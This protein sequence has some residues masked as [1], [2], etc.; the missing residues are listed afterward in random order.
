MLQIGTQLFL[1]DLLFHIFGLGIVFMRKKIPVLLFLL[2]AVS[3][4][5]NARGF[6]I[7]HITNLQGLSNSSVNIVY[8]DSDNLMWFGT[9]DGLNRYNGREIRSWH[10]IPGDA[11]SISSNII[12]DITETEDGNLWIATDRGIDRFDREKE[13][14]VRYFSEAQGSITTEHLFDIFKDR[15]GQLFAFVDGKGIYRYDKGKDDFYLILELKDTHCQNIQT[16]IFDRV[17]ILTKKESLFLAER[18]TSGNGLA[19]KP[20]PL[21]LGQTHIQS[22]FVSQSGTLMWV[23]T[24]DGRYIKYD[25][26]NFSPL[27]IYRNSGKPGKI[28]SAHISESENIV[29]TAK[30]LYRFDISDGNFSLITGEAPVFS[31]LE[32]SQQI[33]WAGTDMHGVLAISN[34]EG[35]FN[36]YPKNSSG[37]IFG[38]SAVRCFTDDERGRLWVGT[39]GSGVF[40]FSGRGDNQR[41]VS[42]YTD[43][44]GLLNNSIYSLVTD[45]DLIWIGSDGLGLNYFD[46]S[47]SR[48]SALKIP[49]ELELGSIYCILPCGKDTLWIG[50]SGKGVFKLTLDKR[51]TP[52]SVKSYVQ[53]RHSSSPSSLSNDVVYSIIKDEYGKIWMATRGGGLCRF[54]ESKNEFT[55]IR[56]SNSA[57]GTDGAED[58]ICLCKD[59]AGGIWAGTNM[60]VFRIDNAN[61]D[62][63]EWFSTING[64][65]GNTIRGILEDSNGDIWCSTNLGLARI[66]RKD[67][68]H[69]ISYNTEDGLHN[70]EFSDLAAFS[71]PH[72]GT[73]F[74]GGINGYTWFDPTSVG[75]TTSFPNLVLDEFFVDNQKT[76][77][78]SLIKER[79]G[80][81]ELVIGNNIKSVALHFCPVD[82]ISSDKCEIAYLLEGFNKDWIELGTSGTIVLSKLK[83]GRYTLMVKCSNSDR[84]WSN[85][86]L[87]MPVRVKP[88]WYAS[89][90]ALF[91]Y[92]IL[93]SLIILFLVQVRNL[94]RKALEK[95][96]EKEKMKDIHEAKLQFF[97]NIAHEFSNSLTLIYGPCEDLLEDRKIPSDERASLKII[98]SN[99]DRMQQLIKQ[100]ISF[101]KA[102]TGHLN[103]KI[104][105]VDIDKLVNKVTEYYCDAFLK[106]KIKFNSSLPSHGFMWPTDRD[107]VEKIIFNFLS[108]AM[109]YTPEG[110]KIN[111]S[112][113]VKDERMRIAVTNTGVGIKKEEQGAVFDRYKVLNKFEKDIIKGKV[114]NGIGLAMC[115]NLAEL[116]KGEIGI[117][118][119]ENSFTTF[120]VILPRLELDK[121]SP[122]DTS[123]ELS[124]SVRG[125]DVREEDVRAERVFKSAVNGP[126]G[127]RKRVLVVDDDNE[128]RLFIMNLIKEQYAVDEASDGLEALEKIRKNQADLIISDLMM[129]RMDGVG[130]LKEIRETPNT[131]HIPVILLSASTTTENRLSG[132]ERGADAYLGK[133]F[134][135]RMLMATVK[136]LIERQ[137]EIRSYSDSAQAA[138]EQYNDRIVKKED[139][140]L[141]FKITDIIVSNKANEDLS[142]DMIANYMCM[143][144]IQLYRKCKELTGL[145]PVEYIRKI[146]LDYA[147]KLLKTT[148]SNIQEVMFACGFG[149]KTYF[150]RE[151]RKFYNCTPKQYR[152]QEA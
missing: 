12:R 95:E 76:T 137:E 93:I 96:A 116:L 129:P 60:G 101:R 104:E 31:V 109:K 90:P 10:K 152:Q 59:R 22:A 82:Y 50:S 121:V 123:E 46:K 106:K 42:H 115:K 58:V 131:K 113:T 86:I 47:K 145:S 103:I 30:G 9:W 117:D 141:I 150:Y 61:P 71:S 124:D 36:R 119:D 83:A 24:T 13:I 40:V 112:V 66:M 2:T 133:P 144:R 78:N 107:S 33:L 26:S 54:D 16:D 25:L 147:G 135:P 63:L 138:V 1:F 64:M 68:N 128:V 146:R 6:D 72:V 11:S 70:N 4:I 118:S 8:Q 97:T 5:L 19:L 81:R 98:H 99:A 44:N 27:R 87:S 7:R 151:F 111:L 29:G 14:F 122:V 105:E 75:S 143:S 38:S 65:P 43:A 88:P 41:L 57:M 23:Q 84:I 20:D 110:E 134:H 148:N 102:E 55:T 136:N 62:E 18:D 67:D 77:L 91:F 37:G 35:F 73:F 79:R 140:D 52:V 120:Y 15:K 45:R 94:K 85:D 48:F 108:N 100:I 126:V 139:K 51:T 49:N 114:S 56:L 39:K 34:E 149:N 3:A 80:K 28:L 74:F 32:G 125:K 17:W 142:I 53:Y 21:S 130:L 92:L 132:I 127:N 69:I 89:T